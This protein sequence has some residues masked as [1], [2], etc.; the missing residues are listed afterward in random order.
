MVVAYKVDPLTAFWARRVKTTPYGSILNVM[1]DRFVIPEYF[2]EDC[3]S[4]N[5]VK[6]VLPLLAD[7]QA[8]AIQIENLNNLLEQLGLGEA[9]AGAKAADQILAWLGDQEPGS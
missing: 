4:E 1:A 5:L 2:Q 9:T 7:P 6:A 8:A 3:R